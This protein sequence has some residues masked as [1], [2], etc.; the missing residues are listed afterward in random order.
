VPGLCAHIFVTPHVVANTQPFLSRGLPFHFHPP[1]ALAR[2]PSRTA[3][4]PFPF[5]ACEVKCGAGGAG[6]RV[7]TQRPGRGNHIPHEDCKSM[8]LSPP[9][10]DRWNTCQNSHL[11]LTV[12]QWISN[13][14]F[15]ARLR[16]AEDRHVR[17]MRCL[18]SLDM[19]RQ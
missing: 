17:G 11:R 6:R 2:R 5:L 8:S 4:V 15:C 13:G 7:P 18:K 14:Y 16:R 3:R 10:S 12:S 1:S 19:R 9:I